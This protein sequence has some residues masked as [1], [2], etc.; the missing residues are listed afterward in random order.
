M[1]FEPGLL[2]CGGLRLDVAAETE[3]VGLAAHGFDA[4]GDVLF[5]RYTDLFG[6]LYDVF[7]TDAAGE[8]LVLHALLHG[9]SFQIENTF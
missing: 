8:G 4:E 2:R 5:E 9:A 6:A 3:G 7:P 1:Q